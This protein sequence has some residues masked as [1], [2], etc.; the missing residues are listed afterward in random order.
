MKKEF[1]SI[2]NQAW[3]NSLRSAE[4]LY[5]FARKKKDTTLLNYALKTKELAL[6]FP[7]K[8]GLFF[9]VIGT[10]MVK[11]EKEGKK[12]NRSKGW[13]AYY[14]GNS[15]RNPY[16]DD[17]KKS[18]FHI[19]DMSY[20]AYQMLI[21]YDELEKDPRLLSYATRYADALIKIQSKDGF[22]PGWLS[23]ETLRP[24]DHLNKSPESSMSVTFL[25]KLYELTK[26]DVYLNSALQA[27]EAVMNKI[28]PIGQ[29]EDFETYWSCS[30]YGSTNLVGEKVKRNNMFKQN[31]LS[32][33]YT[34]QA[35]FN[36]YRIT[37]KQ[38]YL[39]YGLRTLDE[40]LMTQASWQP[41]YIYVNTLGGFGVMNG[42]GEWNDARQSLFAGLIVKYGKEINNTEYIERGL[43][44]LRASFVMMY[45][46][47]N[48]RTK[49]QWEHKWS[50]F[51][52]E[53]YGFMMENYG[54]GGETNREGLGIGEFTIY[55]WG[56]G[57]AAEAL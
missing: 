50:F 48:P 35:L 54:H 19:L 43:A 11:I 29:W 46:P 40:M 8:N 51:G 39:K 53:D 31:T 21:W 28:I 22:F 17:V 12:Y 23:L 36:C 27:M 3:F 4:G 24:M 18:P 44:A 55:D 30:R 1:R 37:H 10:G 47:L 5:R 7:Q 41:P 2:W 57:A 33:Y 9:S 14:F 26:N 25:L 15:N 56:N 34:A 42:D 45:T 16:S 52:K 49:E 32:M 13:D 6:S 38:K 20:I